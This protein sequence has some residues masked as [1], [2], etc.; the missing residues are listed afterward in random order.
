MHNQVSYDKM[1]DIMGVKELIIF[2]DTV[3]INNDKNGI[4]YGLVRMSEK[5]RKS[6]LVE[7]EKID[8]DLKGQLDVFFDEFDKCF[9]P[10]KTGMNKYRIM[11]LRQ[12]LKLLNRILN[13]KIRLLAL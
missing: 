13:T 12:L 7:I 8:A 4:C 10:L 6:M 2:E 1:F 5:N 3:S 9:L 11:I